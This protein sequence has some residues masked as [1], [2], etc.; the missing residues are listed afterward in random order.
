MNLSFPLTQPE[1]MTLRSIEK[2]DQTAG[3][4]ETESRLAAYGF[5]KVS[6][7]NKLALTNAGILRLKL[8]ESDP[9]FLQAGLVLANKE[10]A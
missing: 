5:V 9:A 8:E 1:V 7:A 2:R 3:L 4:S 6:K 10:D